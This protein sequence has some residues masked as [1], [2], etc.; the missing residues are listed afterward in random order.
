MAKLELTLRGDF[1]TVVQDVADAILQGSI[2]ASQEDF[3]EIRTANTRLGV[4]VFERYSFWG[5]NRVSLTLT[6]L[7]TNGEDRIYASAITAG[8][9]QGVFFKWDTLGEDTFL[10][11]AEK[12]MKPHLAESYH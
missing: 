1:D 10:E 6:F 2:S 9:S 4:Y 11:K 12:A 8:G 5:G 3:S 7:Q